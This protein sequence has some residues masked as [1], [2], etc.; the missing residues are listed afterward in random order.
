MSRAQRADNR[1]SWNAATRAHNSHKGDQA[2]FLRHRGT[3]T[4]FPEELELLGSV[5][6]KSV[7][8]LQ[9][10]SGQDTLCLV[11]RGALAT[12]VDLSDEAIAFAQELSTHSGLDA[13]FVRSDV[14]DYLRVERKRFDV[15]FC[16]YGVVGWLDDLASWARGIARVLKRG[17]RFVYV[18]FHPAAWVFDSK[19]KPAWPYA[20][21]GAVVETSP[22]SDYVARS[23]EG[24]VPWG[25][26]AGIADFQNPHPSAQF[27]WGMADIVQALLDAGLELERFDEYPYSNGCAIFEE[28]TMDA[29]RRFRVGKGYPEVP[30]MFG[31]R[32]RRA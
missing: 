14:Y 6:G 27:A 11:K 2:A 16:S 29:Q 3:T 31:L 15:V 25:F 10:N 24:L 9:C 1:R 5:R 12:G 17:G 30:L 4:L 8:H 7:L 23:G 22:V 13:R 28:M 19:G 20:T 18:D 21:S 32:A 26:E